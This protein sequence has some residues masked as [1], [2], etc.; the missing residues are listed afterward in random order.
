MKI[1]DLIEAKDPEAEVN[2]GGIPVPVRALKALGEAGYEQV[3]PYHSEN[4]ISA[5]G[6][7]CSGCFTKDQL[8]RMAR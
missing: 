5:W 1:D 7:A 2:A 8:Q 3:R 6:K 4:T